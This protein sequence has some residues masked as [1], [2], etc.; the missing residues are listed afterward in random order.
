MDAFDADPLTY[1]NQTITVDVETY[2]GVT[3]AP[4]TAAIE[5]LVGVTVAVRD[6]A[7][8]GQTPHTEVT[9]T[10][11]VGDPAASDDIDDFDDD[12]EAALS[13][14]DAVCVADKESACG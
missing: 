1:R 6:Q 2:A 10:F 14:I 11:D 4:G 12:F 7:Q 13:D 9:G 8:Q 5:A 3:T